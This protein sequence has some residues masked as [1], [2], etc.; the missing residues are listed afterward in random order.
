MIFSWPQ[1]YHCG[2][3]G[4]RFGSNSRI[5]SHTIYSVKF[6]GE[7]W[8]NF[9]YVYDDAVCLKSRASL[10]FWWK[11]N[12]TNNSPSFMRVQVEKLFVN[13]Y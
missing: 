6:E 9:E 13:P 7:A 12:G 5:L 3:A 4:D 8:Q 10:Y 11:Q 2:V 1:T